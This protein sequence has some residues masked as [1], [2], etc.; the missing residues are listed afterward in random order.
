MANLLNLKAALAC[1]STF[2]LMTGPAAAQATSNSQLQTA[3]VKDKF[4]VSDIS[5][6]MAEFEIAT[7]LSPYEG[8]GSATMLAETSGSARFI[9]S[10]FNCDNPEIGSGCQGAVVYT[11]IPNAGVAYEDINT[12]NANADVTRAVNLPEQNIILFGRQIFFNGGV[13]RD[14]FKFVSALFLTDMQRYVDS[15]TAAGTSVSLKVDP[16]ANGKTSN[17]IGDGDRI[18]FIAKSV[19]LADAVDHALTAAIA[20]TWQVTFTPPGE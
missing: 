8:N 5:A 11:G 9:I 17:V 1:L 16:S 3:S 4:S 12:F 19:S 13:G 15:Q 2:A 6:I 7:S 14:N 18:E 20:N 10:L